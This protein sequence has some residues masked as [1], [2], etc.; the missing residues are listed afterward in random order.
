LGNWLGNR[1]EKTAKV[2][3]FFELLDEFEKCLQKYSFI[4]HLM[5]DWR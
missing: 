2:Q 5:G 4:E 1:R 3:E